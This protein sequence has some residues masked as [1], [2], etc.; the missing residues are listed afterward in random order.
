M[1]AKSSGARDKGTE[2]KQVPQTIFLSLCKWPRHWLVPSLVAIW[3]NAF[4][5]SWGC[6]ERAALLTTN[7]LHKC[8]VVFHYHSLVVCYVL[9]DLVYCFDVLP[10]S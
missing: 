2:D 1:E 9:C 4:V 5:E 3:S 8:N 6:D 7:F 10:W